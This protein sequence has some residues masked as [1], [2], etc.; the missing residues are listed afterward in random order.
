M[1]LVADALVYILIGSKPRNK[2]SAITVRLEAITRAAGSD[3]E[4]LKAAAVQ[5]ENGD[6]PTT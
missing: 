4:I 3:T 1:G 6:K 2:P 5:G